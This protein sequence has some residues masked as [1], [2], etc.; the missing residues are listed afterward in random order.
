MG[1]GAKEHALQAKCSEGRHARFRATFLQ[2]LQLAEK[3]ECIWSSPRA[4]M[5]I[6]D[7]SNTADLVTL[8]FIFSAQ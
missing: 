8:V 1:T 6:G 2:N 3:I 4:N 7:T 5:G